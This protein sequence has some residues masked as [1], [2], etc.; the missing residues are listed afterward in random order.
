MPSTGWR[1]N[2]SRVEWNWVCCLLLSWLK[3]VHKILTRFAPF[4]ADF[5]SVTASSEI[6]RQIHAAAARLVV[7]VTGGGSAAISRLLEVPGASSTVLE[8]VV[9]Y[10]PEAVDDWLRRRPD[11]YCS[12]ETALAMATVAWWRARELARR[13]GADVG[14]C[15]GIACSASLASN[16][17][18]KGEHRCWIAIETATHSRIVSLT[19]KKGHR[20]RRQEEQLVADLILRS[21]AEC[22]GVSDST[23]LDLHGDESVLVD[24]ER[25]PTDIANVRTG[26]ETRV[27]SLPGAA[28]ADEPEAPP[29]GLLSGAFNPLHVGH[30]GMRAAAEDIVQGPVYFEMSVVNAD[31]PPLD[32]F[33]IEERRRQFFDV[34]VVLTSAPRFVDKA[35]LFPG[36][37][38]VVGFDTAQRVIDPRFYGGTEA[39]MRESLETIGSLGCRFLVA[40]RATDGSFHSLSSLSL[41]AGLEDLF[42]EIPE[43][44]FREDITSTE[45]RSSGQSSS[46]SC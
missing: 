25:L 16:R 8:A 46:E 13:G 18:K 17:P 45:L 10:S 20:D 44:R 34:P 6:I 43:S 11:R 26:A 2:T 27:W 28:L 4:S 37:T 30:R 1:K 33:A 31:K 23:L 12:R 22:C 9:P 21:I 19:L 15:L 41:P 36:T 24:V 38:F 39:A 3:P 5:A 32:G 14:N 35:H 40:G 7:A 42:V 29:A